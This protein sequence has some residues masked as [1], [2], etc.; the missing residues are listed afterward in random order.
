MIENLQN[1][2]SMHTKNK[3][4]VQGV[5]QS[6]SSANICYKEETQVCA[7]TQFEECIRCRLIGTSDLSNQKA[8]IYTTQSG[9]IAGLP[10]L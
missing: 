8:L 4:K 5:P 6:Q 7:S 10:F 1:D 2:M 3:W 9:I